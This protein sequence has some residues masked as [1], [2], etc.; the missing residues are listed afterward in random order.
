MLERLSDCIQFQLLKLARR[1]ILR[2]V[3]IS[4]R[5]PVD[6][7]LGYLVTLRFQEYG[8]H[9]NK[10]FLAGGCCLHGDRAGD[11]TAIMSNE[12]IQS[13]VLCLE[14]RHSQSSICE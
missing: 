6:N 3:Y 1:K 11:F 14:W 5:F 4:V 13:H 9:V 8:I 10:R 7:E 2:G 12:R